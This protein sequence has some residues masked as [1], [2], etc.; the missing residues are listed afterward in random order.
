MGYCFVGVFHTLNQRHARL[1]D[2]DQRRFPKELHETLG[3]TGPT[4]QLLELF[5]GHH[6]NAILA[7][8]CNELRPFSSREAKH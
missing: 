7:L 2:A 8:S 4:Y 5:N 3:L 1:F 6:H